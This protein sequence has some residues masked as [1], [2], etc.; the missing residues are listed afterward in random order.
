L[1]PQLFP[2]LPQLLL[3]LLAS[4]QTVQHLALEHCTSLSHSVE[5]ESLAVHSLVLV[6]QY[7]LEAQSFGVPGP[8][9]P[10]PLQV[11]DITAVHSALHSSGQGV[12]APGKTQDAWAPSQYV[13]PQ[14]PVPVQAVRG[15]VVIRHCPGDS[16]HR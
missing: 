4:T 8:Q 13:V 10:D 12:S 14:V 6:S 7:W 5:F 2:Q 15:V 11:E 1:A 3:S 9:V 16:S